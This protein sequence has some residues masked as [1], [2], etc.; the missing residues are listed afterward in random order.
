[1]RRAL[2]CLVWPPPSIRSPPAEPI[3]ARIAGV[4]VAFKLVQHLFRL[5]GL[6]D[7]QAAGF[8]D[9]VALGTIADMVPLVD[10]NRALV[11]KGL[12]LLNRSA[13]PG[14][15]LLVAQARLSLGSITSTHVGCRICPRLNAAGFGDGSSVA[16]AA[17]TA[18]TEDEAALALV[19]V[20][21]RYRDRQEMARLVLDRCLESVERHP[22][23]NLPLVVARIDHTEAVVAGIV[24]GKLV[25]SLGSAA[26]VVHR[27][28]ELM[29][30]TLRAAPPCSMVDALIA[31]QDLL[32]QFGGHAQ[33]AGFTATEGNL[34][35][36]IERLRDYVTHA[37]IGRPSA[38]LRIDAEV[39]PYE[40]DWQ[41]FT[42]LQ[43]LEPY[44]PGNPQP[45]LLCRRLRVQEYR[46]V[47]GTHLHLTLRRGN[48]VLQAFADGHGR[49]SDGLRKNQE[50]DILFT[51]ELAERNG[52]PALQLRV[53]DI[54]FGP[55]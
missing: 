22:G 49:L 15:R 20:E 48:V 29:R 36:L 5:A 2:S 4:G 33:A 43:G 28:G 45:L 39:S 7:H 3:L 27:N 30:G 24:A 38:E 13:R 18:R 47:G 53:Q 52:E 6:S 41:L 42:Q 35:P 12:S 44:G 19:T 21:K 46:S 16:Y 32:D 1:M 9:L 37:S 8:L 55:S 31:N 34:D 54:D 14:L 25:R 26:L 10:E 17:L 40:I 51:L 50:V 23:K 11:W